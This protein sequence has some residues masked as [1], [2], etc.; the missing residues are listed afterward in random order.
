MVLQDGSDA[1]AQGE[2]KAVGPSE[3]GPK[4]MG[5]GSERGSRGAAV[6]AAAVKG[7]Y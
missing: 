4:T 6:T 2:R 7:L 1:D 5:R 3:L